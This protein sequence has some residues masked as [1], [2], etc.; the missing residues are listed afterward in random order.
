M[1]ENWD[2]KYKTALLERNPA[3]QHLRIKEAYEAV[4][5]RMKEIDDI[6]DERRKLDNAVKMLNRLSNNRL[7]I[8]GPRS[9]NSS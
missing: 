1:A 2:R 8:G 5:R 3:L 9:R 6:C 4:T 7:T